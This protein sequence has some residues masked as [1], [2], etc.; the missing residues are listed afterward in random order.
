[1]DPGS[2][3]R[4]VAGGVLRS[5]YPKPEKRPIFRHPKWIEARCR[6]FSIHQRPTIFYQTSG[7]RPPHITGGRVNIVTLGWVGA[8]VPSALRSDSMTQSM[9]LSIDVCRGH[10]I[11]PL[12]SKHFAEC[13]S[14]RLCPNIRPTGMA[15]FRFFFFSKFGGFS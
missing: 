12:R 8:P 4:G 15:F 14:L 1:M 5:Y 10:I 9:A 2:R 3:G 7:R 11:S 13:F 6:L